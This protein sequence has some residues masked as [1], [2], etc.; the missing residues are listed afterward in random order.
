[1]KQSSVVSELLR[2]AALG[3]ITF[4]AFVGS[5]Q[6]TGA[7]STG[8]R[9]TPALA[10]VRAESAARGGLALTGRAAASPEATVRQTPMGSMLSLAKGLPVTVVDA[11]KPLALRTPRGS[12]V[13]DALDLA[14]VSIGP[15]DAVVARP[16]GSVLSG[17]VIQVVRVAERDITV[18]EAIPFAV[19]TVDDAAL[20]LGRTSVVTA[21]AA[22]LAEN[23]YRVRLADGVETGRS[24][25]ASTVLT[26][27]V[28][29]VRRVGTFVP[30]PAAGG[31]IPSII[32]AAAATWGAD[33]TQMLRV[34]YCESRY[35]PNAVNA[36]SGASGLFQFLPSTW[37]YQSP[38]AGYAGA[39]PFDPVANANVAA[40]MFA[41]G[42]ARQ[43]QCK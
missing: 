29:E 11:G 3:L 12:S 27:A 42:Q 22:G 41:N 38:R 31:D 34:S 4:V 6:L 18:R 26:A 5:W 40:F 16:D 25:V 19:K 37:A 7:A 8:L 2:V 23:T 30:A 15:L 13:T 36:S 14:G 17:D 10:A 35:N 1:M 43:W 20:A 24:L 28:P 33:A 9:T 39:S 21:G 32:R